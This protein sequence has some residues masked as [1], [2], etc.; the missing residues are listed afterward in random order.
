V[1]EIDQNCYS[2]RMNAKADRIVLIAFVGAAMLGL[3]LWIHFANGAIPVVSDEAVYLW[4]ARLLASGKLQ[5]SLPR[6]SEFFTFPNLLA[7]EGRRFGTYPVGYPL[8][9]APWV[10]AGI[11][12]VL[13]VLLAGASLLLMHRFV[14]RLDGPAR[15]WVAV[16]LTTTSPFFVA[17]STIYMSHPLA[18]LLTLACFVALQERETSSRAALWSLVAGAAIGYAGNISPFVAAPMGAVLIA[19]WLAARRPAPR[20]IAATLLPILIGAAVYCF[21]NWRTTGNPWTPAY[22]LNRGQKFGFGDAIESMPFT[23]KM[24]VEN[25]RLRM[26]SLSETLFGWPGSSLVF[27]ALYLGVLGWQLVSRLSRR[28]PGSRSIEERVR[29]RAGWD[30]ALGLHF[31]ATI[32][33]YFFYFGPGVNT[34]GPRY[35]YA[36]IPTFVVFTT[37]GIFALRDALARALARLPNGRRVAGGLM[38]GLLATLFVSGTLPYLTRLPSHEHS[39]ARRGA[40][41]FLREIDRRGIAEGTVFL[42]TRD[43]VSMAPLLWLSDFDERAPLVYAP[44]MGSMRNTWLLKPRRGKPTYYAKRDNQTF[45]W[46]FVDGPPAEASAREG[47]AEEPGEESREQPEESRER[48]EAEE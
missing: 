18:L 39:R 14:R 38:A 33:L 26:E 5:E 22:Y 46:E 15:A 9:L 37:R 34:I 28:E 40:R 10:V 2:F 19:R 42:K 17:Q 12:W 4:E 43:L 27:A 44:D 36:T 16:L 29:S 3:S 24:A 1:D 41:A 45:A 11:P 48:P 30:L 6:H 21:V 8:A 25:T 47:S 20:E 32:G 23:P 31:L 13:N 7:H 35:L